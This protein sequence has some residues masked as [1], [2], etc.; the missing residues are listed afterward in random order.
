MGIIGLTPEQWDD[1]ES[2][3]GGFSLCPA[4]NGLLFEITD[5]RE[6]TYEKGEDEFEYVT[7][8]CSYIDKAGVKYDHWEFFN[9]QKRDM[10][11]I[12]GFFEKIERQELLAQ[13]DSEWESLYGTAFTADIK[14]RINKK[15]NEVQSNMMRNT[16][17]AISHEAGKEVPGWQD[18]VGI[19]TDEEETPRKK[20]APKATA[21]SKRTGKKKVKHVEVDDDEIEEAEEV[22][23]AEENDEDAPKRSTRRSRRVERE[24]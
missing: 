12:K 9:L 18:D 22:E 8:A 5:H 7:I 10:P 4:G 19:N 16:I 15:T 1:I 20:A 14:H 2:K 13:E 3:V 23:E 24:D 21:S 17:K 11:Y 6:S